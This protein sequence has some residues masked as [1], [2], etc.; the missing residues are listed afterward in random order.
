[1][2]IRELRE[3]SPA[4]L[5]DFAERKGIENP[6]NFDTQTLRFNV[7][8]KIALEEQ[9]VGD[10]VL[11]VMPDGYGFLRSAD[12]NYL[13]GPEDVYVSPML[14]KK[15]GLKVGDT[16]E[17]DL[18]APKSNEKYFALDDVKSINFEDPAKSSIASTSTT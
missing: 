6:G 9:V 2:H 4:N 14:I 15:Y 3:Y 12:E 18:R 1:M 5:I 13:A 11:E 17:G 10:G 7:L 16:I 8:K